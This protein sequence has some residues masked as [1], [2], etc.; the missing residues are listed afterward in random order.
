MFSH[1]NSILAGDAL[2]IVTVMELGVV[3]G[4]SIVIFTLYF[5]GNIHIRRADMRRRGTLTQHVLA[6]SISYILLAAF[7]C[8][9]IQG[10]YGTPLTYRAPIGFV[11]ATFGVY[12][13]FNM[14]SF[15]NARLDLRDE[16][17]VHMEG[18]PGE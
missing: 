6:I 3:V 18:A 15:Q 13:L 4:L 17:L 8:A 1:E 10:Y 9:E 2:R 16:Q 11:A 7:A 12:A 5:V 14:V